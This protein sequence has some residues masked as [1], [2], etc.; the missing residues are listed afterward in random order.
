LAPTLVT[1][2]SGE[3]VYGLKAKDFIVYADGVEQ[4]FQLNESPDYEKIS[5]IVAVQ[6]GGSARMLFENK[7]KKSWQSGS[8]LGGLGTMIDNFIG[9]TDS[10]I[11]IVTFD[12]KVNLL[13]EFTHNLPAAVEKLNQ[14]EGSRDRE[15]A[16]LDAI[17]YS[18][19]LFAGCP[20]GRRR[21]LFLISETRDHNS[22]TAK[23]DALLK[24]IT[25][26]NI[27][28]Y[29]IAFKPLRLQL[30]RDIK[31]PSRAQN[32]D[33]SRVDI[34]PAIRLAMNALAKNAV[35]PLADHTGG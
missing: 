14:L 3:I 11:A 19:Q 32:K 10:E 6:L 17:D 23:P 27:Q 28:V 33:P 29:S 26:G 9:K 5:I 8:I 1:N 2:K 21:I 15:A 34:N 16:I 22:R 13:Q 18:L 24:N 35:R 25:A 12:R 20:P 31:N 30:A 7:Q 4:D